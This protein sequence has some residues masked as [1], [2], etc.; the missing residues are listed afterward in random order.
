MKPAFSVVLIARNEEQTLPRLL[1]SLSDFRERG[2]EIVLV[3]T[4][5]SDKTAEIAR[6]AGCVVEE[7]GDRFRRELIP[8][9]AQEINK[10]FV[11][12]GEEAIVSAGDT[13]FD[14]AAARN[15]AASLATNDMLAMPDCDEVYTALDIDTINDAIL[16]EAVQQ[17][18]Y[19]FVFAHD[20]QGAELVKFMHSKFY[21]RRTLSWEGII[22]EILK[23]NPLMVPPK[24]QF[25]EESVIKLEHWQNPE[26]NRG[27]YLKGL[28]LDV[29]Q[30]PEND[31]HAHYF[32]RELLYS[33]RPKSAIRELTRH[34]KM[35][36]WAEER[37]QSFIHIGEAHKQM[38]D[39]QKA[40][41]S[42]IDAIDCCPI[43]REPFMK[44]AEHYRE[45]GAFHHVI[46]YATAALTIPPNNFYA[47]FQPY[48]E[49]LPHE[50][51]YIAYW[52]IDSKDRAKYHYDKCLKMKPWAPSLLHD[53]HLFYE[54]P[55]VSIIIP[56]LRPDGLVRTL[57]SIDRL[58]YPKDLIETIVLED[59]PRIGVPKR[60]AE[61]LEKA[62]GEW[63]CYAADDMEFTDY[64]LITAVLEALRGERAFVAFNSGPLLPD[65]GNAAE[66]FLIYR[67]F[68][69]DLGGIFDTDF[70]H[71]GVDN[72]LWGKMKKAGEAYRSER[73]QIIH[74]HFSKT[75]EMDDVY[76]IAWNPEHVAADRALLEKKLGDL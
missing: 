58:R 73:A 47:A 51:L 14:Y 29:L 70:H 59:A 41:Y 50:L 27:G 16:K 76:R 18:E 53:Y 62:T 37:S 4:G 63:I 40:V 34:T 56:T 46:P 49:H 3:D 65:E 66:H 68:A 48:Y 21:D 9:V 64:A 75:G 12:D 60:V 43:R 67:D 13:L 61:G 10:K 52:N 5:S 20:E 25:F 28:A 6:V 45:V 8:A 31:R 2:G 15:Y 7:V 55:K 23:E 35:G 71:V 57:A 44:I 26:T 24:R 54:L 11:A 17:L 39:I 32:G 1:A 33:G 36:K 69:N 22:H 74:H 42:W 19:H 30:N 72:L 38:G